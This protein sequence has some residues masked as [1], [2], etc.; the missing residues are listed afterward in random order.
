MSLLGE[1]FRLKFIL[2]LAEYIKGTCSSKWYYKIK[3]MNT[4]SKNE[5][6]EWQNYELKKFIKHAYDH[7][8][9]Y[10]ELFDSLNLKPNDI[11]TIE[12]LK[13]LPVLSKETIKLRKDD[14]IPDNLKSIKHRSGK[15]GGTTG[16]PMFYNCD[17]EVWGYIT[18]AKR[19][20]WKT[21]PFRF[22]DKF[23]ALGSASLFKKK[24]SFPR[25]IYDLI[26]NEIALNSLNLSNELCLEYINRIKKEKIYF[27]YGYASAVYLLAKYALDNDIDMSFIKGAFT[28]SENLTDVYRNTIET[29]FHCRVMDCYGCRDA[30]LAAYEIK[31]NEYYVGYNSIMEIVNSYGDG[32]GTLLST[33]ILNYSFPLIRYNFGDDAK[34]ATYN[35]EY[36]GQVITKVLGRTSDVI[37]LG[38]GKV[39][40]TPGFTVLMKDFDVVAYDIQKI[41][42]LEVKV[43][44]Q[45]IDELYTTEQEKL[46]MSEIQ[47]FI[48]DDCKLS[49]EYVDSFS[50]LKNG[51]RRY[52]M[53]DISKK[54]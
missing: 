46:I 32:M 15:T 17:E 21:T 14:F 20:A 10:R 3:E 6:I 4:W 38:N 36:N 29:A 18:A 51:K 40:T 11:K 19:I 37:R 13:K 24:P 47:R 25:R 50:E 48:G 7:T 26:R 30:G 27:I 54:K 9:Y 52:F 33:N 41:D 45:K 23:I 49:I 53:N 42:D 34:L 2:P 31:P 43:Q 5:I 1:K 44:I 35:T 8:V 12:D 22:G 28:T 16:E 39:L